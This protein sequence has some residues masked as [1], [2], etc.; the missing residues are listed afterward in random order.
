MH[1]YVVFL[2]G[3]LLSCADCN[4]A[5]ADCLDLSG[6]NTHMGL[7]ECKQHAWLYTGKIEQRAKSF[8]LGAWATD[9]AAHSPRLLIS[10]NAAG[11]LSTALQNYDDSKRSYLK[12]KDGSETIIVEAAIVD[13]NIY[14]STYSVVKG[15]VIYNS[16]ASYMIGSNER[17][18]IDNHVLV[19]GLL[20][21]GSGAGTNGIEIQV[22]IRDGK[23]VGGDTIRDAPI[24]TR[25]DK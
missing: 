24:I 23:E 6:N 12:V 25:C 3:L 18:F 4:Y 10:S 17:R 5:K 8:L 16:F 11:T 14:S 21:R 13:K 1:K 19:V 15:D 9:C 7:L 20:A 22:T 2:I